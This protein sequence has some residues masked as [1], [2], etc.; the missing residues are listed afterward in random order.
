MQACKLEVATSTYG[1][2]SPSG[3]VHPSVMLWE[4]LYTAAGL[5]ASMLNDFDAWDFAAFYRGI[6]SPSLSF[7]L[8][9]NTGVSSRIYDAL[10]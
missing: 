3:D 1:S 7:L 10:Q 2:I 5:S 8:S 9:N 4:A 6:L